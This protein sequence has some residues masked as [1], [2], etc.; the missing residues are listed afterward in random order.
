MYFKGSNGGQFEKRDLLVGKVFIIL[1]SDTLLLPL[2][3]TQESH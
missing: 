3:S 2:G 1:K